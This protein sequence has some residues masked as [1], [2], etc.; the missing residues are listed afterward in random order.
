MVK[1]TVLE[2]H[3]SVNPKIQHGKPCIKGTR[4]PIHVILEALATGMNFEQVTKEYSP[5]T[6]EDIQ[7]CI[8]YA[9]L[10]ADEQELISQ[11]AT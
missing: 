4:T 1:K 10:L 9:A 5:I 3:I 11:P 6:T 7:A 8:F 2:K